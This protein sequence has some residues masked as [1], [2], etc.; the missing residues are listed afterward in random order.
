MAWYPSETDMNENIV[1]GV[2]IGAMN[3]GIAGN[4]VISG[5]AVTPSGSPDT[6]VSVAVGGY[7][8]NGTCMAYAGGVVACGN[9]DATNPRWDIIQ[10]NSSGV[11]AV[12]N[13][14]AAT[15]AVCPAP[16]A[17]NIR[18]ANIYRAAN[19]NAIG[20]ADIYNSRIIIGKFATLQSG[21]DTTASNGTKTVTFST[22]YPSSG[23]VTVFCQSNT[24]NGFV[25][26]SA[27]SNTAFTVYAGLHQISVSLPAYPVHPMY[28]NESNT[29]TPGWYTVTTPVTLGT[30]SVSAIAFSWIAIWSPS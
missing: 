30:I 20:A 13:G 16:D 2:D 8:A 14:T 17:N 18:I 22:A 26:I 19:D 5:M 4:G 25:S 6:N 15:P 7:I 29:N 10:A 11:V 24:S 1:Q 9:A 21:T 28:S 3:D 12:K 23:T 27:K